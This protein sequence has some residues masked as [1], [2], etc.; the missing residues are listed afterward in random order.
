MAHFTGTAATFA[1]LEKGL[2]SFEKECVVETHKIARTVLEGLFQFTPVWSG[3]TVRNYVAA[4]GRKPSGGTKPSIGEPGPYASEQARPANEAA[5]RSDLASV[6]TNTKL[7]DVFF[8]NLI[9][10]DKW[11][12]IDS[13][14]APEPGLA[15]P[16]YS[17][18]VG[19]RAVQVTRVKHPGTVK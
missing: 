16:G 5:A 1:A 7:K 2:T 3:E 17:G 12:L 11:E 6:L 9:R 19:I 8:T 4:L 15:R 10:A 14:N 13:G 18:A